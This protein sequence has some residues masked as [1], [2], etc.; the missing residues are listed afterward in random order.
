MNK[1]LD[2]EKQDEKE[3]KDAEILKETQ[4]KIE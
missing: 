2:S 4:K 3:T 1:E